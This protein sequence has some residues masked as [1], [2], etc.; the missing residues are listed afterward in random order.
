[1]LA[2]ARVGSDLVETENSDDYQAHNWG[3]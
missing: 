2:T 3:G 1:M